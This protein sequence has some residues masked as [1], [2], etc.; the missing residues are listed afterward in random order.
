MLNTLKIMETQIIGAVKEHSYDG[1]V[2]G[3][4]YD[5]TFPK[6]LLFTCSI[7][8]TLGYGH[9]VPATAA[10]RLFTIGYAVI[11]IPLMLICLARIGDLMASGF[12][13]IYR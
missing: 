4:T 10:G 7:V 3:W 8:T 2:R 6:A 5:W 11:G 12:K 9:I 1:Q 13:R